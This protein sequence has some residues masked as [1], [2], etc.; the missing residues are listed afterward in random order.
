MGLASEGREELT[1]TLGV[2]EGLHQLLKEEDA[3]PI[4]QVDPDKAS[5]EEIRLLKEAGWRKLDIVIRIV[6]QTIKTRAYLES[7]MAPLSQ[8]IRR[9]ANLDKLH[10]DLKTGETTWTAIEAL[11]AGSAETLER[12]HPN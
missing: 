9:S 4:Y 11:L 6:E 10:S 2:L 3:N 8:R 5:T 12:E 1:Y 7:Y